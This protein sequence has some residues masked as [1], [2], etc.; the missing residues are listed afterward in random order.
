MLSLDPHLHLACAKPSSPPKQ[1]PSSTHCWPGVSG[2]SQVTQTLLP[3]QRQTP[4]LL[5]A[6]GPPPCPEPEHESAPSPPL[7]G[8]HLCSPLPS[9]AQWAGPPGSMA[10]DSN[11]LGDVFSKLLVPRMPHSGAIF[12]YLFLVLPDP[13]T[14]LHLNFYVHQCQQLRRLNTTSLHRISKSLPSPGLR[15]S[16]HRCPPTGTHPVSIRPFPGCCLEPA[17]RSNSWALCSA[18]VSRHWGLPLFTPNASTCIPS[19]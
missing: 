4:S 18:S 19:S 7:G 17:H 8:A 11:P 3:F 2:T 10:N 12:L 16:R 6:D 14:H 9:L 15:Q 5:Q 1:K 13:S